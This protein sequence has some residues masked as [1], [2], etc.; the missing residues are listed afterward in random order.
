MSTEA[1]V[2]IVKSEKSIGL[3]YVLLIFLGTFG[4]H[5]FYL[6]RI[7]SAIVQLIIGIIGVATAAILI[8]FFFLAPLWIWLLIDLFTLPG[9]VRAENQKMRNQN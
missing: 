5:R 1:Q 6:N 2:V 8:G 7:G 9:M 4:I 3:A